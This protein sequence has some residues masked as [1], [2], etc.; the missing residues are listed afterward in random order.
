MFSSP[1]GEQFYKSVIE[2]GYDQSFGEFSSPY[3]EQFYKLAPLLITSE[4]F[5]SFRPLTGNNFIN[6]NSLV[7][8][9]TAFLFSSPYGEQFYKFLILC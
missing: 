9:T 2:G 1:Y 6:V 7:E 8:G 5:T 4:L 3:G